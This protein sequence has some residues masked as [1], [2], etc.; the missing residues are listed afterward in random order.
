[1]TE[2]TGPP[3]FGLHRALMRHTGFLINR[4]AITARKRFA[5]Q[6]ESI[7]LNLRQWGV[8]N[9]L[10][11]EGALTQQALGRCVGIDPSSMVSTIDELEE[12]GLVERRRH[13]SDRRAHALHLTDKGRA[14]LKTG[15]RLARAA[16]NELLAPLSQAER[17]QLHDMLLR[18]AVS[19]DEAERADPSDPA[20]RA[21]AG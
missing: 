8:L 11:A 3:L 19:A 7:G 13:P 4:I 17:D 9:V 2:P 14:T 12:A 15:R 1:M 16:Q 6:M 5:A 20:P 10:D 18:V 21:A